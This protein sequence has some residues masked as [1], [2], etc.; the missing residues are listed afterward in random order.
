MIRE[1]LLNGEIARA[2]YSKA[3]LARAIGMTPKTF[4]N[5]EKTGGFGRDDIANIVMLCNI[6]NPIPIFFPE[7]V[8]HQVT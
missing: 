4:Y 7:F 8:T 2:G 5:K 1:D 6:Q 3:A